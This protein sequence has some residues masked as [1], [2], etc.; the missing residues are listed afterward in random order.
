MSRSR[1]GNH[2][3]GT[4][5][6][7]RN[8]HKYAVEQAQLQATPLQGETQTPTS[9]T[10]PANP[11]P[12]GG[13]G[14]PQS[15]GVQTA[16]FESQGQVQSDAVLVKRAGKRRWDV[17]QSMGVA[18]LTKIGR[19]ALGLPIRDAQGREEQ[20]APL[21]DPQLIAVGKLFV[22]LERQNQSD[23]HHVDRIEYAEKSLKLRGGGVMAKAHVNLGHDGGGS[24]SVGIQVYLPDNQRDGTLDVIDEP[25]LPGEEPPA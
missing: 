11:L 8:R 3:R 20:Y 19:K 5:T 21:S 13:E 7:R 9:A 12:Q 25:R 14:G 4:S 18:I 17:P 16:L 6:R 2:K 22:D 10:D 15:G 1:R 23:E 24:A